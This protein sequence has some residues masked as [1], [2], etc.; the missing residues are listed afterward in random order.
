[1]FFMVVENLINRV[2]IFQKNA[3]IIVNYK[4]KITEINKEITMKF[5][6]M[7]ND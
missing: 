5:R 1:M 2:F 6:I 3:N 7:W 4:Y